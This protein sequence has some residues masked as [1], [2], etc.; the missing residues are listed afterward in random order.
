[1]AADFP[2]VIT[3]D[4][5]QPQSPATILAALLAAVAATNPGYTAN[6]PASLIEDISSTDV[7]AIVLCD[8]A[9]VEAVNSLTPYGAN[10]FVLSQLGQIYIGPGAA[11]AP[12]SNT[13]VSVVFTARDA[14]DAALPGLTIPVGFVVGDGVYQYIVQDGGVTDEDGVTDPLFC[15]A[16]TAGSWSIATGTVTQLVTSPPPDVT[17]T[18][19]NPLAGTP[20]G[21]AETESEF[22]ARVLQAGLAYSQGLQTTLKTALAAVDGVQSRLV[23]VIQQ[24][25]GGW[26]VVVGGGDPYEVAGAIYA[27]V[28]DISS[29]VGATLSVT[30]ITRANPGVVTTDINHGYETGQTGV[31][32]NGVVGPT[33]LNGMALPAITVIDEKTFS[34]GVSTLPYAP[35][36]SGGEVTPVLRNTSVNLNDYPD[37]YTVTFVRPPEQTVAIVLTWNTSQDNFVSGAAV[38]QLGGAAIVDY[39]N[40]IRVGAPINVFQM[41]TAFQEAIRTVLAPELLTRMVFAVSINGEGTDPEPGTGVIPGDPQSYFLTTSAQVVISQG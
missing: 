27:S 33:A 13:S 25:G 24:T 22:R 5:L 21:D 41:Q 3:S 8:A 34:I 10:A 11:P 40:S 16:T 7:A 6:L 19:T 26:I 14:D 32:L 37:I 39:I 15:I 9:K 1:M 36:V 23:S 2:V 35:Y 38:S 18:C 12:A 17:L 30:D 20:G 28:L 4:G 29:L 31:V